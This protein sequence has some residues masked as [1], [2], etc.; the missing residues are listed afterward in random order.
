MKIFDLAPE[1]IEDKDIN[2]IDQLWFALLHK[3]PN[4]QIIPGEDKVNNIAI[5]GPYGSGKSTIIQSFFKNRIDDET[6]QEDE[7]LFIS[8][9][10]FGFKERVTE[11]Q[12][13]LFDIN[14]SSIDKQQKARGLSSTQ[15][16]EKTILEKLYLASLHKI[17]HCNRIKHLWLAGTISLLA[18]TS[19]CLFNKDILTHLSY[20]NLALFNIHW[21]IILPIPSKSLSICFF[22]VLL[23]ILIFLILEETTQQGKFALKSQFIELEFCNDGL[24]T[25]TSILASELNGIIKILRTTNYKY[26]IFEDLDRLNDLILIERLR[27]LNITLNTPG[28]GLNRQIKFI[29]AISDNTFASLSHDS[30]LSR[31]KFFDYIYSVTPYVTTYNAQQKWLEWLKQVELDEEFHNDKDKEFIF[32]MSN[33]IGDGRLIK[34]IITDYQYHREIIKQKMFNNYNHLQLMAIV[35]YKNLFHNDYSKL[36]NNDGNLYCVLHSR[37]K[38]IESAQN[39][40]R[41]EIERLDKQYN[42]DCLALIN[43]SDFAK[44]IF[45]IV[46]KETQ[47]MP[48]LLTIQ[49]DMLHKTTIDRY[50]ELTPGML[51]DDDVTWLVP[52]NNNFPNMK[53][54]P[55]SVLIKQIPD[56]DINNDYNKIR[57]K[58]NNIT[59]TYYLQKNSLNVKLEEISTLSLAKVLQQTR[60]VPGFDKNN[61]YDQ[62]ITKLLKSGYINEDYQKY[63]NIHHQY[64]DLNYDDA[65]FVYRI[66][67]GLVKE[68]DCIYVPHNPAEVIKHINED[69]ILTTPIDNIYLFAYSQVRN[70]LSKSQLIRDNIYQ[71]N[72]LI[73]ILFEC[74]YTQAKYNDDN[75]YYTSIFNGDMF[76]YLTDGWN[77]NPLAQLRSLIAYNPQQRKLKFVVARLLAEIKKND[78]KYDSILQYAEDFNLIPIQSLYNEKDNNIHAIAE[79]ITNLR[80]KYNKLLPLDKQFQTGSQ[81]PQL[82]FNPDELVNHHFYKKIIE[83]SSY[84]I[85]IE[86]IVFV[87]KFLF[88]DAEKKHDIYTKNYSV[89]CQCPTV[90]EYINNNI[91]VYLEK[92]FFTLHDKQSDGEK[93][94][95]TLINNLNIKPETRQYIIDKEEVKF[96]NITH[97]SQELWQYIVKNNKAKCNSCNI[98]AYYKVYAYDQDFSKWVNMNAQTVV[99]IKHLPE[100]IKTDFK[101]NGINIQSEI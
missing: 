38:L 68:N 41:R 89:I 37:Y 29:Y 8:L 32:R 73:N 18:L 63:I 50:T 84:Q 25:N 17:S 81:K 62:A 57:Q 98:K 95:S 31:V 1:T 6:I 82:P 58:Y 53:Y 56:Q 4:G 19:M 39:N 14:A 86:N 90:A 87:L 43:S 21:L 66:Q 92:V 100:E 101:R 85:N 40:I 44:R 12:L 10:K 78:G 76:N 48:N 33:Y 97:I 20:G 55:L 2:C 5:T 52:K 7:C 91:N 47:H 9:A 61:E 88:P 23:G 46:P 16:F 67:T 71:S 80:I 3:K 65:D 51:F 45:N 42:E 70:E 94:L 93:N 64:G 79:Q 99:K 69:D 26:I 49:V 74:C 34:N 72:N 30:A 36:L 27:D 75:G 22:S 77:N 13:N 28:S 24:N 83:Q 15:V 35:I 54:S 11:G 60:I 59:E 96:S